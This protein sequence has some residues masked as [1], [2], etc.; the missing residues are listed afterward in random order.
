MTNKGAVKEVKGELL[1]VQLYKESACSHCSGCD[2]K[3]KLGGIY[4]F[5]CNKKV[6]V[7]DIIT[8][9]IKEGPLLKIVALIYLTPVFSMI[10][11]YFGGEFI[12]LSEIQNVTFA[13]T[14][15]LGA[16]LF[17]HLYDKYR[18]HEIIEKEISVRSSEK[19]SEHT[20]CKF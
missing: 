1:K 16:F 5:K 4:N 2:K 8:F 15:F 9:E 14:G 11:G 13:F 19:V 7:G 10:G 3:E 18:G 6:K 17:I 12:G 20:M